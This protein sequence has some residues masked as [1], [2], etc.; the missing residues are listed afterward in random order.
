MR[1]KYR[2]YILVFGIAIL[3]LSGCTDVA[4]QQGASDENYYEESLEES[5]IEI[6]ST[7]KKSSITE[8]SEYVADNDYDS[9]SLYSDKQEVVV[10]REKFDEKIYYPVITNTSKEIEINKSIVGKIDELSNSYDFDLNANSDYK[11]VTNENYI[12][13]VFTAE[14]HSG[15]YPRKIVSTLNLNPDNGKQ[16]ALD[17]IIKIDSQSLSLLF[18]TV[19]KKFKALG[20]SYEEQFSVPFESLIN[21]DTSTVYSEIQYALDNQSLILFLNV[22]HAIGDYIEA[23]ILLSELEVLT[24]K[25]EN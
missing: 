1:K 19:E 11:I 7:L 14:I 2:K 20:T 25:P 22:R 3:F 17:Q 16:Y 9:H 4:S 6:N 5:E 12:S 8:K 23:S 18:N 21:A 15:A 24:K 10:D 13:I